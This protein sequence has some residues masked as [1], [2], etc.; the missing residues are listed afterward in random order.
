MSQL[1]VLE[2]RSSVS[3]KGSKADAIAIPVFQEGKKAKSVSDYS[4]LVKKLN[5]ENDF[6]GSAGSMEWVRFGAQSGARDVV[7]MGMGSDATETENAR[8]MGGKICVAALAKKSSVLTIDFE[9]FS[10]FIKK[11]SDAVNVVSALVEGVLIRHYRFDDHKTDKKKPATIKKIIVVAKKNGIQK[12]LKE[13]IFRSAAAVEAMNI[14]RNWS[15]EPSNYGTPA[16]FAK[17]AQNFAKKYG[18][19]C[20]V[21]GRAEAK[22]EKMGLFLGVSQGSL[23]EPKM[24]VLEYTPKSKGKGKTIAL[25]GKGVT[26]DTGGISLKPSPRM[27]EMKHDMTGAATMMGAIVLAAKWKVKNRIVCVLGFCENK[28]GV[29]A[30]NPGDIHTSRAGKTVEILNTDAEGRLVLADALDYAQDYKPDVVIDAATLTGAVG[31]ALGPYATAIMGNDPKL[32]EKVIVAGS[33]EDERMWELPLYKEHLEDM[34]S[35][36]ADLQNIGKSNLAGTSKAGAFLQA[37][38]RPKVKWAHLDIAYTATGQGHL[39][40][41]PAKGASGA[42]VRTLAR[43]IEGY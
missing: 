18:L 24:V 5:D 23:A 41:Y 40:Y 30:T 11:D 33:K 2:C 43:F 32:V 25:V 31:I 35:P 42:Q 4:S 29:A 7:L 15:N 19:K 34:K 36:Y 8:R 9:S 12:E 28:P 10:K 6:S 26:F 37:F 14:T 38:I 1:P 16:I 22:R 3:S 17:D 20:K 13:R 27:D 21:L 39:P